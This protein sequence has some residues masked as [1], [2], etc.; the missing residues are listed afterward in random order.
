MKTMT[1]FD[2]P[3]QRFQTQ[4]QNDRRLLRFRRS[5]DGKHLIRFQSEIPGGRGTR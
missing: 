2:F 1:S 3:A 4:I 5:V